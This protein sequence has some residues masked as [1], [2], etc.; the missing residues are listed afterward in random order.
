MDIT[1]MTTGSIQ[2][3][4]TAVM[5]EDAALEV[6]IKT[7]LLARQGTIPGSR[8]FGLPQDYLSAPDTDIALNIIATELQE[9]LDEYVE[10]IDVRGVTGEFDY[11]G[12]LTATVTVERG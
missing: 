11:D 9:K 6:Y 2:I 7:L 5:T 3:E 4:D 8:N 12:H 10:D 1:T